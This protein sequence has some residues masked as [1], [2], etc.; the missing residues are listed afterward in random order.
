VARSGAEIIRLG[1][2][3]HGLAAHVVLGIADGGG[4][5]RIGLRNALL[6]SL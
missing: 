2:L 4:E 3:G 1:E 6:E 5:T